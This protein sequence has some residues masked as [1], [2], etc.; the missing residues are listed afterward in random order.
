M[1]KGLLLKDIYCVRFIALVGLAISGIPAIALVISAGTAGNTAG[2]TVDNIIGVLPYIL[3]GILIIML[4]SSFML[5]TL[6][7]DYNSGWVRLQ[8]TLPVTNRQLVDAKLAAAL[9]VIGALTLISLAINLIFGAANGQPLEIMLA[10]PF[11]T[12][13]LEI[14]ALFPAFPISM[15]LSGSLTSFICVALE[16]AVITAVT[17]V[18]TAALDSNV[19]LWLL[20][21]IFYAVIPAAAAT[22]ALVSRRFA[23]KYISAEE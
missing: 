21:T 8:H 22:T 1:L 9:I 14:C 23:M 20:R 16:I 3:C 6:G 18:L 5:N 2:N 11:V 19:P 17:V 10:A 4:N 13:A 12:A 7:E 15:K